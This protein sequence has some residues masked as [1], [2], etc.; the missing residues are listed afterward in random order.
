M[1][2]AW[3]QLS[4]RRSV[5]VTGTNSGIGLATVLHLS[6]L[7]FHT[8]GTVRS[9]EKAAALERFAVDAGVEVEPVVL[10]VTD[11][12]ACERLVAPLELYALVNNAGYFNMGAVDDVPADDVRRQLETMVIAPTRLARLALVGM[13]RQGHGRIVNVSSAIT[14]L[15]GA[16][17]GWYQASKEALSAVSDALRIEVAGFGVEVV[18]IEPGGIDTEIWTKAEQDLIRHRSQA[19][20]YGP[21][22]DRGLKILRALRGRMSP[23]SVV[24]EVIGEALTAGR[25]HRRYRVGAGAGALDKASRVVSDGLRDRVVRAVLR[26]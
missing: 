6:R 26:L 8:I 13:R 1:T 3:Y 15:D 16:V 5:L 14:S 23:P 21:T 11:A 25:P 10:D 4:M 18:E 17:T 7:G 12:D 24:A 9:A 19:T 22:Y 2:I 20:A